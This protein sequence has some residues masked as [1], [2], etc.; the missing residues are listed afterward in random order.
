MA[1]FFLQP[2][3]RA[4]PLLCP[5]A[6]SG[7]VFFVHVGRVPRGACAPFQP[8]L[9]PAPRWV[10]VVPAVTDAWGHPERQN[11]GWCGLGIVSPS[12][13][14]F[15]LPNLISLGLFVESA[16]QPYLIFMK[17]FEDI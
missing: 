11:P 15:R 1:S 6:T 13:D 16:Q 9:L 5:P 4:L 2:C 10:A 14:L 12:L 7:P 3:P 8:P 17:P